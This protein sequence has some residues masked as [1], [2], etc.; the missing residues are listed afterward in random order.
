MEMQSGAVD[1]ACS[2]HSHTM[3]RAV[4]HGPH[5]AS[6]MDHFAIVSFGH[7]RDTSNRFVTLCNG[8]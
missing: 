5:H 7:G 8:V 6:C 1:A 2:R 4:V 3:P